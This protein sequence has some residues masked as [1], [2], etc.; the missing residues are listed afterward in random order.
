MKLEDQADR[1]KE[2]WL[3]EGYEES[4]KNFVI[5]ISEYFTF[6]WDVFFVCLWLC[7]SLG[8]FLYFIASLEDGS[9]SGYNPIKIITSLHV[10][11]Q[12]YLSTTIWALKKDG[13][14]YCLQFLSPSVVSRWA[15]WERM[16]NHYESTCCTG[17]EESEKT[18]SISGKNRYCFERIIF[19]KVQGKDWYS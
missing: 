10:Q 6:M 16:L 5:Q 4:L 8:F 9:F 11:R 15:Q 13:H 7:F 18:V 14:C 1:E 19:I 12:L 3:R 17:N 2:S